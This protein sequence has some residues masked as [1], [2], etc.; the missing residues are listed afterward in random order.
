MSLF[1]N[2]LW[3]SK[4][5][6]R[7]H[8]PFGCSRMDGRDSLENDGLRLKPWDIID[9]DGRPEISLLLDRI[10]VDFLVKVCSGDSYIS[11]LRHQAR[12]NHATILAVGCSLS[13]QGLYFA[14]AYGKVSL[15]P[16]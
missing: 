14:P 16:T 3:K 9:A 10:K 4:S 12:V 7:S 8:F 13:G 2:E 11:E 1:T 15:I 6:S 5:L